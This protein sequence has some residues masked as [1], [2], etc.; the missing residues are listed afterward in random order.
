MRRVISAALAALASLS[1]LCAAPEAAAQTYRD[2]PPPQH[3]IVYRDLT[4]FRWN[5]LGLITDGRIAYRY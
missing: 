5:P 1:G 3:R 4:L 2:G